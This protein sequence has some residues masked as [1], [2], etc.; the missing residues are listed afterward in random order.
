MQNKM[1]AQFLRLKSAQDEEPYPD[2]AARHKV[3]KA[4]Q[5]LLKKHHHELMEAISE[6]FGHRAS[7][8]T[9]LLEIYPLLKSISYNRKHLKQWMS[10]KKRPVG[11]LF[12]PGKARLLPQPLG[13]AGIVV[14]WNYPLFLALSPAISAIAA[15]NRVCLKLSE[16]SPRLTACLQ[17]LIE[18]DAILYSW[19][20]VH[21]GDKDAAALFTT[22]PFGHLLYTGSGAVGKL[23]MASAAQ[24]LC[25]ITLELGGKSPVIVAKTASSS[26][27]ERI[28][29]GKVMNAGQT[30]LAPDTLWIHRSKL[31]DF[32]KATKR[33]LQKHY[34][35]YPKGEMFTSIISERHYQRLSNFLIDAEQTG[36]Q[37]ILQFGED[38]PLVRRFALRFVLEPNAD[39]QIMKEEIFGPILPVLVYDNFEDIKPAL[40]S[41][42]TPLALYYFGHNKEEKSYLSHAL[43]SGALLFNDTISHVAID[44]LPFGGV[45]SSGMGQYHG[46]AGFAT[47]S[48]LKPVVTK[49]WFSGFALVYPPRVRRLKVFLKIFTG[50][51]FHG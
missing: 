12:R 49:G 23:V 24:N 34:S 31:S 19:I 29:S 32:L 46:Y 50:I 11:W 30:C 38:E 20:S 35:A 21:G 44:S 25:P 41:L 42:A 6:D 4:L 16:L 18:D 3:L 47:F 15:G 17:G 33:Y 7:Y 28:L 9:Y 10:P 48:K 13:V 26:Y 14:P 2:L 22:L 45:G 40:K 1:E 37:E 43:L 8:E 5:N 27:F 51:D 39:S 36:C